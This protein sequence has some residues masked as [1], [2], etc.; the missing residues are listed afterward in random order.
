[1]RAFLLLA[2]EAFEGFETWITKTQPSHRNQ[3]IAIRRND[4]HEAQKDGGHIAEDLIL[5]EE[6]KCELKT[7]HD[8]AATFEFPQVKRVIESQLGRSLDEMFSE[9]EETP[10]ASA[11]IAQVHRAKLRPEFAEGH[12][13]KKSLAVAVKVQTLVC[14]VV[15]A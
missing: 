11:S 6:Y 8:Q 2:K 10:I 5:P 7:L 14:L 15:R 12:D 3:P 13:G 4:R 9:F 1:M